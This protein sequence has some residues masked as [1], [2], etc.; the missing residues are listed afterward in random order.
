MSPRQVPQP[1]A[2]LFHSQGRRRLLLASLGAGSL[3]ALAVSIG[4]CPIYAADS[5]ETDPNCSA[6]QTVP[7]YDTGVPP[8]EC[9]SCLPG[10]VCSGSTGRFACVPSDCRAVEKAC[11]T[12][13]T[14]TDI[15]GVFAC[16]SGVDAGADSADSKPPVIDCVTTGCIVGYKCG[17]DGKG[18]HVCAS[19]DPNACTDD[20]DCPAKTGDGS[21]CLGGVCKAPKDLCTDSAQC[22][23]GKSCLD[24]RCVP[25]CSAST[26]AAGYACD[27]KSGLCSGGAG[28][29][30][31]KPAPA[32][33][34]DAGTDASTDASSDA[35]TDAAAD[36][37]P[38]GDASTDGATDATVP[39][40][41]CSSSATCVATHCVD[42]CATDGSCKSG[43]VCVG[44]GCVPDE[45]PLFFCDKD[46]T[47]DGT[48]DL[49]AAGSI[50]LHHNCY[51]AC[52]GAGDTSCAKFDKFPV[53]KSV[54]TSSGDHSVCSSA[55]GLGGDC[56]PTTT[57]P[58]T[59][60]AG[61]V[62]LDGYCK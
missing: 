23:A 32:P 14:C 2:S 4:G 8:S 17:P 21:L 28:S 5:C 16:R 18:G 9:G 62:C 20:V 56:D 46:G 15:G 61:K 6:Q 12:G 3:L 57:P 36:T 41:V 24:G 29:C 44:G 54:T 37:A 38:S 31:A 49:C 51:V 25:K 19:T 1:K 35:G 47:K 27:A 10:Y 59:C 33:S 34:G 45:R 42:P 22:D 43:L 7:G 58:K 50:C 55:T 53:C 26:C 13:E 40:H 48:Q 30:A 60:S 11:S 39:A 52:A